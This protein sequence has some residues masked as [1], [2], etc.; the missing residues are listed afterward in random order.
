MGNPLTIYLTFTGFLTVLLDST[1]LLVLLVSLLVD[2][3]WPMVQDGT[4]RY[5][6]VPYVI[7]LLE[8]LV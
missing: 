4:L 8:T 6:T 7:G 2:T 1:V 3:V 5:L